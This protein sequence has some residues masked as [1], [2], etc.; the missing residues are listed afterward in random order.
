MSNLFGFLDFTKPGHFVDDNQYP[1]FIRFWKR[2]ARHF[3]KLLSV[4][5]LFS[6]LT[7]PIY[8]WIMSLINVASTQSN[9]GV[10]SLMGPVLMYFSM[11]IPTP[12]LA[13]LLIGSIL[14]SGP[15]AAALTYSCATLAWDKPGL[16]WDEFK[17]AFKTNWKQALPIGILD[18]LVCFVTIYYLV[19]AVTLFGTLGL[20][21][22][23]LWILL[24]LLYAMMRVYLYPVMVTMELP[25]G[26]LIKNSMILALLS[27]WRPVLVILVAGIFCL[28]CIFADLMIVPCF[29]YSFVAYT[30]A[31]V[32]HPIL[33]KY[34][35]HP[36]NETNT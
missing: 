24:A 9:G 21:V 8:T 22:T 17:L 19:D 30:A 2:Y 6:I 16:F 28:L 14:V 18:T 12:I 20:I 36:N 25:L 15:A 33:D 13:V 4:N 7:L 31:F 5:L 3:I 23:I 1:P 35:F 10:I 32:A 34:L 26:A 11:K 29:L 27:P